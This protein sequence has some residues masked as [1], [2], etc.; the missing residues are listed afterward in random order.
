MVT[1]LVV[2]FFFFF[3]QKTAYEV[4]ISDWSSDVCSSDLRVIAR[5]PLA[6]ATAAAAHRQIIQ[7]QSQFAR[8]MFERAHRLLN[9][10]DRT[11]HLAAFGQGI[12]RQ[13][14]DLP[15]TDVFT[16]ELLRQIG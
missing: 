14:L 10:T 16:E 11:G 2:F 7:A 9:P 8:R 15:R 5:P 12:A 4:R 3:K 6:Q 13:F 1:A